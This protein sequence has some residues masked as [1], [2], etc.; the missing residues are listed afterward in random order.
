VVAAVAAC[1]LTRRADALFELIDAV[2][3]TPG[4]VRSLA[5]LSLVAEHRRGHAKPGPRTA[6]R[7]PQPPPRTP[8]HDVGKTIKRDLSITARKQRK[9]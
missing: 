9:G 6:T 5:E 3:C 8:R 2:L 1:S 7:L 4:P